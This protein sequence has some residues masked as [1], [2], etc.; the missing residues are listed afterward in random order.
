MFSAEDEALYK[1][2]ADNE[3]TGEI[4]KAKLETDDRVL[5][6]I[7]DGIYRQPASAL[8]ELLANAYDADASEVVV[9]MDP[10]RFS[11]ISVR[12]DGI[13]M[14]KRSLTRL[15]NH[16]G[17]SSKRTYE[18]GQLGIAASGD[19]S[20]T[21]G[22]RRLIG[23][24]GIGLFSVSQLTRKFRILTKQKGERY[25]LV[26]E[27]QLRTYSEDDI[28][29]LEP[30]ET[31]DQRIVTGHVSIQS[32]LAEDVDAHGTE[33]IL[34]ELH[35]AARDMLRSRDIW[36]RV[37]GAHATS[38][39]TLEEKFSPPSY[40]VGW[41][42]S[43]S[44][45]IV[46][47]S[48]SLPWQDG[49]LPRE[50]FLKLYDAVA[51]EVGKTKPK[52]RLEG[53][54]DRYLH[55]LWILSLSAPLDYLDGMHPFDLNEEHLP[56]YFKLSN[57]AKGQATELKLKGSTLRQFL[58]LE[59]PQRGV[60]TPFR[61]FVDGVELAR[62]LRFDN[63]PAASRTE[64]TKRPLLFVGKCE[65]PLEKMPADVVGGRSLA[66]EAY[67]LWTPRVAPTDHNG[68][69]VRISDASGT[70]F[71][72]TFFGYQVAE[73]MRLS[74]ITAE[75]F[76][77]R[78]L[79]AAL[80]IDR[81]SFNF[82]HPHAKIVSSWV[83]R[84]LRQL[85]NVQKNVGK[86]QREQKRTKSAVQQVDRLDK[87][88]E[89][90]AGNAEVPEAVFVDA[91]QEDDI[92]AKR[93]KGDIVLSRPVVLG[94][95]PSVKASAASSHKRATFERQMIALAKLLEVHGVFEHM[96][97]QQQQELLS[98]IASIFGPQD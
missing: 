10:P 24:I 27:V 37:P 81:E 94:D 85:S 15:I 66:F 57:D 53:T 2:L 59:A 9:S 25:R 54:L 96:N 48:E 38:L 35:P 98:G 40:H 11:R 12:D 1:Q 17:G 77:L 93:T 3:K 88:V 49:D 95:L 63:L 31:G 7:T 58:K 76:V 84:A 90:H 61:V 32:V 6:R 72:A 5:A 60:R 73:L 42:D 56:R 33:I 34:L 29:K 46:K 43:K 89:K 51:R 23:K 47:N 68:V 97:Y 26:A 55:T 71:D 62:P 65:P 44:D 83:H 74:Q 67:L 69:M 16:I 30:A 79:D 45:N 14:S 70:L 86:E 80:N 13:G 41:V 22:G 28:A 8:R 87:L 20:L 82:G 39:D 75:I 4:T 50:K 78:G 18:G 19:P 91:G 92:A 36:E 21:P 64:H 52:P